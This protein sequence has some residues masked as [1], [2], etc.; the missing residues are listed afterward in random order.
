MNITSVKEV[1][2]SAMSVC[3]FVCHKDSSETDKQIYRKL[4]LRLFGVFAQ[5]R[6]H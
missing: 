1:M 3:L 4:G 2:F 5:N 6:H